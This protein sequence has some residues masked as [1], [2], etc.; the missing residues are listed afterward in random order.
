MYSK[1]V[2]FIGAMGCS[3]PVFA[4]EDYNRQVAAT[5]VQSGNMGYVRLNPVPS[6][7][8][9]Y[10]AVYIDL[11]NDAGKAEFSVILTARVAGT[12][13]AKISYTKTGGV[14]YATLV[15]M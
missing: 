8:C 7:T 10:D 4:T 3:S 9:L 14:C 2:L 13:L 1:L 5:G 11:S 12:T 6:D 15:E